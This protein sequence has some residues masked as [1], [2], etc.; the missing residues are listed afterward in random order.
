MCNARTL[1]CM[2]DV[3]D[4][5]R[6]SGLTGFAGGSTLLRPKMASPVPRR[7][8]N[9]SSGRDDVLASAATCTGLTGSWLLV[10]DQA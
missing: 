5:L 10:V 6:Q 1:I 9:P 7:G 4:S 3:I 2:A 8:V